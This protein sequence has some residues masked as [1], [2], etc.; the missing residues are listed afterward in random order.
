MTETM[1]KAKA[2]RLP[3]PQDLTGL[4]RERLEAMH[5]AAAK[6]LECEQA[7]AQSGSNVVAEVLRDQGDF[8][9]WERYPKG[10]LFDLA[11]HSHYFY[12]A[13]TRQE[14]ADGE[15]GHFHLFVR[16]AEIAADMKPWQLPGAVIPENPADRF[17]HIAAISVDNYGRL[18][19]IF[20]TNRW[21]T[22]ETLYRAED[23]IALLDHFAIGLDH[24]SR[25]LNQW[26]T[27]LVTLYRPQLEALLRARDAT[28]EAWAKEHPGSEILEDRRLQN[29]SEVYVDTIK[30]IEAIETALDI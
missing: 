12:H 28:L 22:N 19:R 14:M 15:N 20:T 1:A 7:L 25:A 24:P 5:D 8:L 18:I 3:F 30:Q 27:S 29:T 10:D 4:S 2:P 6:V 9:I 17:A 13:H 21:V 11:N 23:V 26:L 16:P